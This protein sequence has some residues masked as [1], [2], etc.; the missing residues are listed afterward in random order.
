MTGRDD[1]GRF[2]PG[3]GYASAGGRARAAKLTPQRRR[4]IAAA[5][6][7]ALAARQFGGDRAA[8]AAWLSA[9]GSWAGLFGE[10]R[11]D[12]RPDLERGQSWNSC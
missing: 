12:V 1:A 7:A 3:N 5:G 8:A 9:V 2:L 11:H 6:L 10:T 4:E